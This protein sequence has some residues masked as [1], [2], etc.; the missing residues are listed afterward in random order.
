VAALDQFN[1]MYEAKRLQTLPGQF[2]QLPNKPT[3]GRERF[4]HHA[5]AQI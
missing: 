5:C 3:R 2:G 4:R 1:H